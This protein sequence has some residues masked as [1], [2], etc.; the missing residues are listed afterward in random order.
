RRGGRS[1]AG[2]KSRP[3]PSRSARPA[4]GGEGA[5]RR[6]DRPAPVNGRGEDRAS[7]RP[8]RDRER[9]DDAPLGFG[10]NEVP[11]FFLQP[12]IAP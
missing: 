3:S 2:A 6:S 7:S 9:D 12:S 8:R 5:A 11:A 1:S 10:D 4:R